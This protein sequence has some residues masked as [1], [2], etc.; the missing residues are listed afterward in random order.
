MAVVLG[1][2]VDNAEKSSDGNVDIFHFDG[3]SSGKDCVLGPVSMVVVMRKVSLQDNNRP[4][5][6]FSSACK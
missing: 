4:L 1:K 5:Y 2:A 3:L 6:L